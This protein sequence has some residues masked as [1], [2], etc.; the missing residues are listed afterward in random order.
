M[1]EQK[2]TQFSEKELV[3]RQELFRY[4]DLSHPVIQILLNL[5]LDN[6]EST[7]DLEG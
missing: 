2:Q 1:S 3:K 6:P 4:T 7:N 5:K